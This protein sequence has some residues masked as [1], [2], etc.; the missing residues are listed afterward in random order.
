MSRE[1]PKPY[2]EVF[3]EQQEVEKEVRSRP[4]AGGLREYEGTKQTKQRPTCSLPYANFSDNPGGMRYIDQ[5]Y[6]QAKDLAKTMP[7][8]YVHMDRISSFKVLRDNQIEKEDEERLRVA[9]YGVF[10]KI[11]PRPHPT[12]G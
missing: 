3:A 11:S 7:K 12:R 5:V 4:A 6:M 8:D 1:V 10:S 9:K 2:R